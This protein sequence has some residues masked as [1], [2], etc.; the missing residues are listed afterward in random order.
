MFASVNSVGLFGMET[1]P[2]RV[3]ADLSAG[4][5]R[6]DMVGLPDA[7]VSESRERV[8]AA[9]RN[10]GLDFP[11][12]RVTV[13]LA[14]ADIRKEGPI[15]DLPVL[16]AILKATGQLKCDT[17]GCAFF[18]RTVVKRQSTRRARRFADGDGSEKIRLS[19]NLHSV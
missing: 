2:V 10:S 12:S 4:L 3:E 11:V 17:E 13:N 14:P 9:I 5:P 1:Y 8:R 19:R 16:I 7:A 18:R 6:F 15:Y